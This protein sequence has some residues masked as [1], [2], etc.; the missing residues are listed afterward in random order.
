[1]EKE[2]QTVLCL[3]HIYCTPVTDN[4]NTLCI[5]Y[6]NTGYSHH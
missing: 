6:V 5:L 2:A 1:M 3:N 4:A